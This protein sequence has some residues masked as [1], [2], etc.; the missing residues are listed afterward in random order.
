[1]L[2]IA[3]CDDEMLDCCNIVKYIRDI[4]EEM[5]IPFIVH[6]FYSGKDLLQAAE[7]FDIIF[8]DIL[9]NS[10]NGMKTAQLLRE[11]A[12]HK[13]LVFISSSREYVFDAYDVEA[14]YY[15]VK[16]VNRHKL[17]NLLKRAVAKLE[18]VSED[19]LIIQRERKRKKLSCQFEICR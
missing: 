7:D 9:M 1:M 5:K 15:L 14:F 19:F 16:P 6:S 2:S 8:L 11:K 18:Q 17:Q 12:F 4:L 10:M 13:I 3:V